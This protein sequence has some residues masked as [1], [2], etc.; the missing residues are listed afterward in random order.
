MKIWLGGLPYEVT[1]EQYKAM[2]AQIA[3]EVVP[4]HHLGNL[5]SKGTRPKGDSEQIAIKFLSELRIKPMTLFVLMGMALSLLV[6]YLLG[7]DNSFQHAQILIAAL[8]TGAGVNTVSQAQSQVEQDILIGD[9]DT[10]NPLRGLKVNVDGDTPI[11]IQN[12]QPL[13]SVFSKLAQLIT[14]TVI[15]LLTKI[16]TGRVLCKA[17][18]LTFTNDAATT[19]AIMWNSQRG[20]S[21]PG[22]MIRAQTT[23]VNANANTV[24][25]GSD[26]AYLAVTNPANVNS[27]DMTYADG[28][29]NNILAVEADALFAKS[30]E[31]EANGRLDAVV[32]CFDN[33]KG[34]ISSVKVNCG[35]TAV[36]VMIVK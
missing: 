2:Q 5:D 20:Q 30:N 16:A 34:T 33:S 17:A 26:F 29:Q 31:T 25:M 1:K 8:T 14:G 28:T 35:A 27:F 19:P 6:D 3:K 12:S 36:T 22:R 23:T 24:F 21:K 15:G 18:V 10:A 32:T 13:V 11:D 4:D 7:I 9:I